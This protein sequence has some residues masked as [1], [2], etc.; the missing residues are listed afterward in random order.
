MSNIYGH[1]YP[2]IKSYVNFIFTNR[3]DD[4]LD[5]YLPDYNL[6]AIM[7]INL[8]TNKKKIKSINKLA[9]LNKNLIG[10]VDEIDENI[11]LNLAYVDDESDEYKQHIED[12]IYINQLK[13]FLKQYSFKFSINLDFVLTNYIHPLDVERINTNYNLY[14]YIYNNIN[15]ISDE[16]LLNFLKNGMDNFTNKNNYELYTEFKFISVNGIEHTKNIFNQITNKYPNINI[17]L[18]SSPTYILYSNNNEITKDTHNDI[19]NEIQEIISQYKE[20]IY[21]K[22]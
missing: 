5:C 10:L 11:I 17:I 2:K 9:P 22:I 1:M 8:L 14:D 15:K 6:P 20:T 13:I 4:Y 12:N 19:I 3:N 16:Q 18:K 21:F 7:P